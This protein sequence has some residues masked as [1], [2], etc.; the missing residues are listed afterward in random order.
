MGA[1]TQLETILEFSVDDGQRSHTASSFNHLVSIV[2]GLF[3][4]PEN[5]TS[6]LSPLSLLAPVEFPRL[7]CWVAAVGAGVLLNV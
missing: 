1:H 3:C 4:F 5:H 7:G 2:H 6:C